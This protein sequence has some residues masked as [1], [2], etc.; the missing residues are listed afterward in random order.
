LIRLARR[1]YDKAARV[2]TDL[3]AEMAHAAAQAR[4]VWV[5]AKADSEANGNLTTKVESVFVDPTDFSAIK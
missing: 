3:R 1:D 5:K 4:P 2:P